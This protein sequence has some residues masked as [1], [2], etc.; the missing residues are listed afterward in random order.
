MLKGDLGVNIGNPEPVTLTGLLFNNLTQQQAT[1][2]KKL[3]LQATALVYAV[4]LNSIHR[5]VYN[6][7]QTCSGEVTDCCMSSRCLECTI[8]T[9]FL[10]NG[11]EQPNYPLYQSWK[12][13][14]VSGS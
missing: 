3:W 7:S 14:N 9:K 13:N 2:F 6:W 10:P 4:L 12:E 5:V 8:I 11:R 1:E